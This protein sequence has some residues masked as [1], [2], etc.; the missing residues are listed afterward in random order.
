MASPAYMN[1]GSI[2]VGNTSTLN[3]TIRNVSSTP[4]TIEQMTEAGNGFSLGGISTPLTL[5]PGHSVTVSVQFDP[6]KATTYT[7]SLIVL[8]SASNYRLAVTESGTA[9][10]SSGGL[11]I[12]PASVSF[13]NVAVGSSATKSL[14]VTANGTGTTINSDALSNA[15]YSISGISLPLKLAAGKSATF[16]ATFTPQT[17]G[18][19]AA[20]LSVTSSN[21]NAKVSLTGTGTGGSQHSVSLSWNPDNST[22]AGYNVY[23]ST[24]SAGPYSKLTASVD[25]ATEYLDSNVTAGDTYYYEVTAVS[26]QGKESSPTSP[27]EAT[28]P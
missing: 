12:S 14:T 15:E 21:S 16:Q 8:S 7:G 27:V 28:I 2:A 24:K 1:F 13:G 18:H 22:V 17:A 5:A 20:T 3:Q 11:S 23:R 26:E 4:I 9:T 19:A 10:A 6:Q 25:T